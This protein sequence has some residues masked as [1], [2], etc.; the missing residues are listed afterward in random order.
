M[1]NT[2]GDAA[3]LSAV[4]RPERATEAARLAEMQA[5][6]STAAADETA[7]ALSASEASEALSEAALELEGFCLYS[8]VQ[9]D[10]LLLTAAPS[11]V[12]VFRER[13]YG[14]VDDAARDAFVEAPGTYHAA[15]LSVAKRQ[16]ELI[17]MLRLQEHFP[18]A[19]I[20]EIMRQNA[21]AQMGSSVISHVRSF[22][23]AASQTPTHFVEKHIDYS[24]AI[25]SPDPE[26]EPEP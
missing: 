1:G 15:L 8:A 5:V 10:G 22:Q 19:S 16:P 24:C 14:F 23:D 21:Q 6:A 17:H 4:P 9:R 2:L 20:A 3:S 18:A 7:R 25:P 26:P 13:L 12:A 11:S